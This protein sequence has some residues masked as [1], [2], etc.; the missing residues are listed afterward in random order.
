MLITAFLSIFNAKVTGILEKS[1]FLRATPC[2]PH[3]LTENPLHVF[4]TCG[5]PW[6]RT[7]EIGLDGIDV[8]FKLATLHRLDVSNLNQYIWGWLIL[9]GFS[10]IFILDVG[11]IIFIVI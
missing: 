11:P 10:G 2:S 4:Y 1:P 5:K 9:Q 8:I 7:L 6:S 3:V